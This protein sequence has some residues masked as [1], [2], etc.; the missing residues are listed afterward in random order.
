MQQQTVS[1]P[2]PSSLTESVELTI[3]GPVVLQPELLVWVSGGAAASVEGPH[4]NW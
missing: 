2:S 3:A 1:P 4:G